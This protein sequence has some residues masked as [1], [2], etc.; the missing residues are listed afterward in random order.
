MKHALLLSLALAC[1]QQAKSGGEKPAQG[2]ATLSAQQLESM[3]VAVAPVEEREV[4][5]EL[6][7]SGRIA[8]DDL[9]V[10]HV[11]SPVTGRIS[12]IRAQ[13]GDK[14]QKGAPLAGL[15]SPDLGSALADVR[16]AEA[17]VIAADHELQ[18]QTELVAV[19]AGAQRDLEQAEDT[20]RKARAELDRARQRTHMLSRDPG[21]QEFILRSPIKGEVIARNVNPGAEVQGQYSGGTSPELFTVG[22]LDQVWAFA[23]VF[24]IDLPQVK[25]GARVSVSVVAYPDR[26]FEGRIDWIAGALDPATRTAKVRA[27]LDNRD[28][29]L[30]PEMYA[31]VAIAVPRARA[32]A[33]PRE[34]VLRLGDQLVVIAQVGRDE[35]GMTRFAR[36]VVKVDESVTGDFVPVISGLQAGDTVVVRGGLL[37]S[38]MI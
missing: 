36:R 25:E 32:L 33:I 1:G 38:G 11:F 28:H 8:F 16:K 6:Q 30:R 21:T 14:V 4:G 19:H 24:E 15:L 2:W 22:S 34:A 17:D 13:P 10:A 23:D 7:T 3:H 27:T 26:K 5:G 31:T 9:R 18:R 29:A 37:L 35:S 12:S 20:Q